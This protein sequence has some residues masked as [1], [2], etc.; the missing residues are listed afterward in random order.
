SSWFEAIVSANLS[1]G[2]PARVSLT[3][4]SRTTW[5]TQPPRRSYRTRFITA[6]VRS[7]HHVSFEQA[8]LKQ[9]FKGCGIRTETT[10]NDP[11]DVQRTKGLETLPH[12]REVGRSINQRLL[13]TERLSHSF[14]VSPSLVDCI[15]Q[16]I[17]AA[18]R[19]AAGLRLSDPR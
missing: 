4:L 17:A 11:T 5:A 18:S 13:H 12:L 19:R 6:G 14:A 16:P 8:D 2:G 10:F 3:F 9:Y 7:A 1:L 15:H